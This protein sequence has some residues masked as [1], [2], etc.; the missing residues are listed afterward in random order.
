[1]FVSVGSGSRHDVE[2]VLDSGFVYMCV[3]L[4]YFVALFSARLVAAS[5]F[6]GGSFDIRDSFEVCWKFWR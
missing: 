1:M 2:G 6:L 4:V 3:C 5:V